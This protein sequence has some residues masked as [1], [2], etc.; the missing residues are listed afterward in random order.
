M[1]RYIAIVLIFL[2][3]ASIS[4][5]EFIY[6]HK[7]INSVEEQ[8]IKIKTMLKNDEHT[9]ALKMH[10]T[11]LQDFW[12]KHE[13]FLCMFVYHQELKEI[14]DSI[15]ILSAQIENEKYDDAKIDVHQLIYLIGTFRDL[16]EFNIVNIF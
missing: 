8:T 10:A 9:T 4:T 16:Y 14:G 13:N 3:V 12:E 5:T 6:V 11:N 7:T 1:K 15:S 2:L